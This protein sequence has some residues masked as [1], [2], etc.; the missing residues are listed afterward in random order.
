MMMNYSCVQLVRASAV[1][2]S[3]G[4]ENGLRGRPGPLWA[5]TNISSVREAPCTAQETKR[6]FRNTSF[7]R[8]FFTG[9]DS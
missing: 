8:N 5:H 7:P 1:L 4:S 6:L 9:E 3:Q 2:K